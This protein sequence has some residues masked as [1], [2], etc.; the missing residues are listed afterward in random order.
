MTTSLESASSEKNT[1]KPSGWLKVGA[2]AAASAFAGGLLAA[3]WY[4]KTLTKLREAEEDAHN[5]QFGISGD[6][7]ADE[8]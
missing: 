5:P 4:R 6:D 8:A 3:Y 7:P 2:V 1:D